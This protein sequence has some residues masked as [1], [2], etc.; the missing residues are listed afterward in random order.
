MQSILHPDIN[1]LRSG[2]SSNIGDVTIK[3]KKKV[4]NSKGTKLLK[5]KP[6]MI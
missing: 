3:V 1:S 4:L 2:R 6:Q 5:S